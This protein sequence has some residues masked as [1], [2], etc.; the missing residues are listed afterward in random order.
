MMRPAIKTILFDVGGVIVA[1]LDPDAVWERRGRLAKELG[2]ENGE[3]MWLYFY[4]SAAWE[5]TK[6]GR[7]AHV[8]MWDTLLRPLG[9]VHRHQQSQFVLDLHTGEGLH[10]G[11][12]A[13]IRHLHA[14]YTL[15]ILSNWDDRLEHILAERLRI[16][17]YFEAIVNSHRIGAAKPSE[18]AFH[19]ALE[20]LKAEPEEV[21]FI[22]NMERNTQAAERLGMHTHT[23]SDL[24]SLVNDLRRRE[25]LKASWETGSEY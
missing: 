14:E 9:L 7:M 25:I 2:F 18:S 1:P 22:D 23:F 8:E 19:Q 6:T 21:L 24:P 15:G 3:E 17:S 16:D 4:E 13:L 11:M 12:E 20:R 10:P 5:A